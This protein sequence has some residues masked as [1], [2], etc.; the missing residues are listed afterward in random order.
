MGSAAAA[1]V[2]GRELI[3]A[4]APIRGRP[5]SVPP[6][7][8]VAPQAGYQYSGAVAA[9]GVSYDD[10]AAESLVGLVETTG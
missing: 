9:T 7:A 4:R 10:A 6:A 8:V 3:G 1:G 5:R 2:P